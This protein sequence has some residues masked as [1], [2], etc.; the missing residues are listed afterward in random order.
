M[1]F[2]L[3]ISI[4]CAKMSRVNKALISQK[5]HTCSSP[6]S[7]VALSV[8]FARLR[9]SER[10]NTN[11]FFVNFEWF[12][13]IEKANVVPISIVAEYFFYHVSIKHEE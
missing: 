2:Y 1:S 9:I 6:T 8:W 13:C 10:Q 12:R 3:F 5:T 7:N 4:L 11:G